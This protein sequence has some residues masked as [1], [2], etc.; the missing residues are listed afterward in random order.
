MSAP[1]LAWHT[2]FKRTKVK[3]ELLADTGMLLMIEKGI[4]GG[5]CGVIHHYAKANN[6]YMNNYDK[7]IESSYIFFLDANNLYGW[8]MSQK[9]SVKGFKWV[10][11]LSKFNERFIKSYNENSDKGYFLEVDGEYGRQLR[12]LHK[13]FPFLPERKKVGK[14]KKLVCD[15]ENKIY[16][17]IYI[18]MLFM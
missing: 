3:L 5:I 8:S 2:C 12:F 17:Y 1:G 13:D 7:T 14:V 9:L 18:Y 6:K 10:E 15:V 16:I 4:R 11:K